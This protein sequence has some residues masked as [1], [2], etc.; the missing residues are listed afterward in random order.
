[1]RREITGCA[2]GV[3]DLYHK[4]H[5]R[6]F[7]KMRDIF[8]K[9]LVVVNADDIVSSYKGKSP[10]I[11]FEDRVELVR[12][13][14]Y[15]DEVIPAGSISD[16]KTLHTYDNYK[17]LFPKR[18]NFVIYLKTRPTIDWMDKNN[19]DY[20]VQGIDIQKEYLDLWYEEPLREGK[21]MLLPSTNDYHTTDII[22]NIL[23]K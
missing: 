6:L 3:F 14:K 8:D 7:Q 13:C 21:V 4:G 15:V 19:I 20:M 23:K 17:K 10:I 2:E 11:P 1:M 16:P 9:V 22:K 12:S 18:E 5:V